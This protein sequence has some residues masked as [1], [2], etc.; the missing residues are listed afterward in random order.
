MPYWLDWIKRDSRFPLPAQVKKGLMSEEEAKNAL[1]SGADPIRLSVEK[2]DRI[3]NI[4]DSIA[5]QPLPLLYMHDFIEYMGFRTCAMCMD[6]ISKYKSSK[7][8]IQYGSDKC[9]VCP[10]AAIDQ[11][12]K[13]GSTYDQIEELMLLP[14]LDVPHEIETE[15]MTQIAF[16]C[17]KMKA[18]QE[19]MQKLED[20]SAQ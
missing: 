11:C 7:G 18:N 2:W 10:L 13:K 20:D 5:A 8:K 4:M 15:R 9:K 3:V 14:S 6:S 1:A 17:R 16:L 12:T 19:G